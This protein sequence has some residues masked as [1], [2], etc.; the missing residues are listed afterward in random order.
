MRYSFSA[1]NIIYAKWDDTVIQNKKD[2]EIRCF[3]VIILVFCIMRFCLCF[4][5]IAINR[6][7]NIT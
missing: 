3:F 5:F 6:S 1:V 2:V 7:I 4:R